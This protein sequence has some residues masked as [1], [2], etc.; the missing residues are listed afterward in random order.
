VAQTSFSVYEHRALF[1]VYHFAAMPLLD[2][3]SPQLTTVQIPNCDMSYR[4]AG[5]LQDSL[6]VTP[7][8]E[9]MTIVLRPQPV[10]RASTAPPA[11][12]PP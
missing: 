1:H 4:A 8:R 9:K 5:I 7:S 2:Q 11:S 12:M 6:N 3:I 10:V